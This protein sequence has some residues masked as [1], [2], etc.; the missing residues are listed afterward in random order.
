MV[1]QPGF[2][3]SRD[4]VLGGKML[5]WGEKMWRISKKTNEI[6]FFFLGGGGGGGIQNLGGEI[7]PPKGPEKKKKKHWT[8]RGYA[9]QYSVSVLRSFTDFRI[10]WARN[11][12]P[13]Q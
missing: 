1:T 13:D 11:S 4:V 3:F 2:F 9:A 8:Q 10:I 12:I 6:C 5:L 7:F